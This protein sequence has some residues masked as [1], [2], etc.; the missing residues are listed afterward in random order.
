MTIRML[1]K[2]SDCANALVGCKTS[3]HWE[4]TVWA[5]FLIFVNN[6]YLDLILK[7]REEGT[8]N[9]DLKEDV[10]V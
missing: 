1:K 10:S 7:A 9:I 5:Y 4:Y 6:L 2:S 3:Y 8:S